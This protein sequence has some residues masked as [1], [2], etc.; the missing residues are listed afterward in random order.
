MSREDSL[1]EGLV[2]DGR[3]LLMLTAIALLLS[4]AFAILLAAR[5]EFVPHDIAYLGMSASDLCRLA[6]CRVVQFMFHDR[7]AFGGALI[8]IAVLYFWLTA[9]PL[10]AGEQWAW[11]ALAVSGVFGF[12]SF[13]AYL[14]YGYFDMWH[15][16]S[17]RSGGDP[18]RALGADRHGAGHACRGLVAGGA[19]FGLAIGVHYAEGYTNLIHLALAFAGAAL[20]AASLALETT[21]LRRRTLRTPARA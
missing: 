1:L 7:V 5:R 15:R 13:L 21:G 20:F 9:Y 16:R 10:H 12:A 4:G 3:P 11:R 6:D 18:R 14:G 2:E 8:A 19:G 17:R